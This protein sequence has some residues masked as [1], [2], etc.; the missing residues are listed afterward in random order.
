MFSVQV[1]NKAANQNADWMDKRDRY[2]RCF[3]FWIGRCRSPDHQMTRSPDSSRGGHAIP[4]CGNLKHLL[5]E[6]TSCSVV[7]KRSSMASCSGWELRCSTPS[8]MPVQKT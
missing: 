5:G 2:G 8:W 1:G 4:P 6:F 7:I 3:L